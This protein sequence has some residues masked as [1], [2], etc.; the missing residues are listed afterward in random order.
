M[1]KNAATIRSLIE[2]MGGSGQWEI[3]DGVVVSVD[4]DT[5]TCEVQIAES[6]DDPIPD[7]CFRAVSD[8]ASGLILV[9]A[10]GSQVV[11][12]MIRN[13]PDF[14]LVKT[15]RLEKVVMR[16]GDTR[17][18]INADGYSLKKENESLK[19]LMSDLLAAILKMSFT[20]NVGPTIKLINF[21]EFEDIKT[22]FDNLLSD[23]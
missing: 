4:M 11:F 16:I 18:E 10:V 1:S 9:P 6:E 22:R 15:S 2:R 23:A 14:V 21:M 13:Q 20:T 8:E 7:V 12:A 19:K 3:W 17:M 5:L